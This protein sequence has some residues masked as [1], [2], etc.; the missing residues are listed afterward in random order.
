MSPTRLHICRV[1][2]IDERF[3]DTLQLVPMNDTQMV[4]YQ[5]LIF[6]HLPV[7]V[8]GEHVTSLDD[9][10]WADKGTA[11]ASTSEVPISHGPH[12]SS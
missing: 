9:L 12:V 2:Q 5:N 8:F 6:G 3:L 1:S 4:F 10:L 11:E 7:P